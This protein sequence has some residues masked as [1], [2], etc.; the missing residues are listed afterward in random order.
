MF[1]C[2]KSDKKRICSETDQVDE[3]I[4]H[5][6]S[7]IS[8]RIA[9]IAKFIFIVNNYVYKSKL[10]QQLNMSTPGPMSGNYQNHRT[11]QVFSRVTLKIKDQE[12]H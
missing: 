12:F 11:Y 7:V 1:N 10:N 3:P 4:F 9:R 2:K 8:H 6:L 5:S